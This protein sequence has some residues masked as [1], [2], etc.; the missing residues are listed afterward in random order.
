MTKAQKQFQF[1]KGLLDQS[2]VTYG[3][4]ASKADVSWNM[5]WRWMHGQRTS[6]KV[7]RAFDELVF[8]N[9]GAR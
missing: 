8:R 3:M 5:V 4:V 6:A 1:R 2:K 9:G 7:Q